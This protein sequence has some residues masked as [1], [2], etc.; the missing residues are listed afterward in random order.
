MAL[1]SAS[2]CF[3]PPL[4]FFT[5]VFS[6]FKISSFFNA[7]FAISSLQLRVSNKF[8]NTVKLSINLKS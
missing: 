6:N 3:S 5:F 1:A 2:R 8:S 4:I 7:L